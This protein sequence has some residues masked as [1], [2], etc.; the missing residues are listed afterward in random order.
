MLE[1]ASVR[2]RPKGEVPER[3]VPKV[4]DDRGVS[5]PKVERR[6][7]PPPKELLLWKELEEPLL[8]EPPPPLKVR[9][10]LKEL[11]LERLPPR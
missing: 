7:E 2:V 10:P 3:G 11:P 6:E 1:G 9:E 4:P 8:K 5:L